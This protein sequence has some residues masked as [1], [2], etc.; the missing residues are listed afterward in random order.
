MYE[1]I[2]LGHIV[3]LVLAISQVVDII[4]YA[5][6]IIVTR[7]KTMQIKITPMKNAKTNKPEGKRDQWRS[8]NKHKQN[9]RR[10]ARRNIQV[11]QEQ[12]YA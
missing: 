3:I 9:V 5:L 4:Q 8:H 11:V 2:H 6:N 12:N 10:T 7:I 1:K